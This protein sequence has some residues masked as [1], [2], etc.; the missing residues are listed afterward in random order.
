MFF[1]DD[2]AG[3][4]VVVPY[5]ILISLPVDIGLFTYVIVMLCVWLG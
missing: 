2:L 5:E 3:A 1:I 4:L